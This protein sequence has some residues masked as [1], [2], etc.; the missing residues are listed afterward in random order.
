MPPVWSLTAALLS[1]NA[2]FRCTLLH[3]S[4]WRGIAT[5]PFPRHI[6]LSDSQLHFVP[7]GPYAEPGSSLCASLWRTLVHSHPALHPAEPLALPPDPLLIPVS[8]DTVTRQVR[9]ARPTLSQAQTQCSAAEIFQAGDSPLHR[10]RLLSLQCRHA[11]AYLDTVPVTPYRCLSDGDFINGGHFGLGAT[12]TN[13]HA[14]A[15]TYSRHVQGSDIDHVMSCNRLSGGRSRRNDHW[16]EALSRISA[17][18]GCNARTEPSYNSVGVAAAGRQGVRAD[19]EVTLPPPHG[20]TLMDISMIHPRCATYVAA[21]SQT[22]GAAA[23][24]RDRDKY[25]AH[26]GHLHPGHTFVPASFETYGHLSRPIMRYLCTLSDV[27]SAR[28]L[29]VTRGSFPAR[30]HRELSVAFV[31]SQGYAY[32]SGALL[33]A[34]ASGRPVLPGVDA[35]YL[36]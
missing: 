18:A 1:T 7:T 11:G 26:A 14:P 27:A 10:A 33:L 36:D 5:T 24:L 23:A 4:P 6:R 20:P 31:Q 16:K 21:A 17:R 19:I 3:S 15:A 12:G 13:P 30:A 25:R 22:R 2:H 9:A 32:R 34:K 28:S 8:A 29:A 35:P